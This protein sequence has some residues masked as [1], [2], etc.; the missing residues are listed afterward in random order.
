MAQQLSEL[1]AFKNP[2][3]VPNTLIAAQVHI[4]PV[5]EEPAPSSDILQLM[6]AHV[7]HIYTQA[8]THRSNYV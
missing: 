4:T 3:L 5:S 2:A 8:H 1:T 7:T 6:C